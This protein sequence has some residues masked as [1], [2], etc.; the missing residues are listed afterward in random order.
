MARLLGIVSVLAILLVIV[1]P[2]VASVPGANEPQCPAARAGPAGT[3][4]LF[5]EAHFPVYTVN[6]S[7]PSGYASGNNPQGAYA[8]FA[9][10]LENAGFTVR[11]LD[12]GASLNSTTLSGVKVVVIVCSQGKDPNGFYAPV[13]YS[14]EEINALA[15]FVRNGGGLFLI[16]DHTDFPPAIFPISDQFGIKFGQKL[17][18]DPTDHVENTTSGLP[19]EGDVFIV[20]GRDNFNDH[21]IMQNVTR[22]ELYRTDILAGL[23]PEAQPLIISDEDTYYID[24]NGNGVS[25]PRSIVSAAIPSNGT[26]G[27]GRIVVVADT[28]TFETD[29]NRDSEDTEMDLFDS[30]NALYGTQI[31]RWLDV[32]KHLGVDIGSAEKASMNQKSVSHD[33]PAG[34]NTTFY[35]KVSNAGNVADSYG[36]SVK[37][38]SSA[39]WVPT[40][41][42]SSVTL[43]S[44]DA[45]IFTLVVSV[46]A[47]TQPGASA[48]FRL[49]AVSRGD[50]TVSSEMNCTVQVP[51]VHNITL[52]CANNRQS[53]QAGQAASYD[54]LLTNRGNV[55][56]TLELSVFGPS[57]WT[58]ELDA[59]SADMEAASS[60]T[61]RLSVM[62]PADSKGGSEAKV[63]VAATIAGSPGQAASAD[64]FTRVI[65]S[66]GIRLSCP[67]PVQAV[68]PGSLV[69]F[70]IIVSN[71]GNGD[72]QV[73]L[74]IP[75]DKR[76]DAYIEPA[77]TALFFNS[78]VQ[79]ALV[80][81]APEGAP[82][83][84][85]LELEVRAMSLR[86]PTA[87]A[88]LSVSAVVNRMGI[89]ILK[90]EP[91]RRTADPGT[92]ALFNVTVS[93]IGN[94]LETVILETDGPATL[95]RT[96]ASVEPGAEA[97]LVLRYPVAENEE[98]GVLHFVEVTGTSSVNSTVWSTAG[99]VVVVNQI[100]NMPAAL[101]PDRLVI[102]P[103]ERGSGVLSI[104]NDG[105]GPEAVSV[106]IENAPA[107]W[108]CI[109]EYPVLAMDART[110]HV[111][112][113]SIGIPVGTRAGKNGLAV[114]I[115]YGNGGFIVVPLT[116]EVPRMFGF[117]C[118]VEPAGR[119]VLAGR[120]AI[121]TLRIENMGNSPE[122]ITLSGAGQKASWVHPGEVFVLLN[123]SGGREVQIL[124]RPGPEA[125]PGNYVLELR[126]SGEGND[127]DNVSFGLTVKDAPTGTGDLPCLL[128]AALLLVAS[129]AVY[130]ARRRLGLDSEASDGPQT[131][132]RGPEEAAEE[133]VS[134]SREGSGEAAGRAGRTG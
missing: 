21:P 29:E 33:C 91:S 40:L 134:T 96:E 103:G 108:S 41:D 132:S 43:N 10:V 106:R 68:D 45:R 8:D 60:S 26:A 104:A 121:F 93:N 2:M 53:V 4:V 34:S 131:R 36:L 28:N 39:G 123:H 116:V 38:V 113:L 72:D 117:N 98:A 31:V 99:A 119:S 20:F 125:M 77:E 56:E 66:F 32:P 50:P 118:S 110:A 75:G 94:A 15:N 1:Q 30:D 86:E 6:P 54:L 87:R 11:T 17:L 81:R 57:G 85:R 83:G 35:V 5:D 58:S 95:S 49:E 74:S 122:N 111:Q 109:I 44:A 47:G 129:V 79:A 51:V 23:P 127:S 82:A 67:S 101:A 120:Q 88:N 69:S 22:I 63:V 78:T 70:P 124:V 100:H 76:W 102:A 114:N 112:N 52:T 115:S 16:G 25:A 55:R 12:F 133:A 18:R 128:G 107:G 90:L 59:V 42:T 65:Q 14:S 61:V 126:A 46:P 71:T 89:F 37:E 24:G 73:A 105:N 48:R 64:T 19:P 27:A 13:P 9:G 130:I 92:V 80:A 3:V 97:S 84:E 62:S 7:N